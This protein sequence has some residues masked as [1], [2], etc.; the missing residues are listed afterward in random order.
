MY[1]GMELYNGLTSL[2]WGDLKEN[3]QDD[4]NPLLYSDK[5]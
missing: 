3:M 2:Y 5:L 4:R 1:V